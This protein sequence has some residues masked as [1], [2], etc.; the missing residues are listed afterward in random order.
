[1]IKVQCDVKVYEIDGVYPSRAMTI[2]VESH[3]NQDVEGRVM[4]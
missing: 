1:M 4:L 3:W 2:A